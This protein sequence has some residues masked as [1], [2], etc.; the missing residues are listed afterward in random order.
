MVGPDEQGTEILAEVN[1]EAERTKSSVPD[2][3]FVRICENKLLFLFFFVGQFLAE[4]VNGNPAIDAHLIGR[5]RVY[6]E[7]C[8]FAISTPWYKHGW[9]ATSSSSSSLFFWKSAFIILD[10]TKIFVI[11]VLFLYTLLDGGSVFFSFTKQ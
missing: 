8:S 5:H 6:H 1:S 10:N 7:V 11:N 3:V 4:L 9:C 2:G